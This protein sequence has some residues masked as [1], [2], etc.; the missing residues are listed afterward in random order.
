L[1]VD[2]D[3][4][5][6]LSMGTGGT[7]YGA[8]RPGWRVKAE[9]CRSLDVRRFAK[10][11]MLQLGAWSWIWRDPD[12]QKETASISVYGGA[13][14]IVLSYSANGESIRTEV[15]I[16]KTACGFGGARPWFQCPRCSRRVGKLYLR[17]SR[18]A[19]R[20]CQ[21]LSYASQAEDACGRTW[22]KQNRLEAQLG[23]YWQR[24]K[25]MHQ[26]TRTRLLAAIWECEE[27]REDLLA[28]YL[29]RLGFL[30]RL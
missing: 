16:T 24:P 1:P 11:N 17:G 26:T 12:T 23:P 6:G 14:R 7:R 28:G 10:E 30:D 18:F 13:D 19:C 3:F 25:Y 22:R 27:R 9:H 15:P 8:G 2:F 4:C 5:E 29:A 21:Q 20:T